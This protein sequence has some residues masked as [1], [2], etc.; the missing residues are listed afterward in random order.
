M[1]GNIINQTWTPAGSPYIVKGDITVPSGSFLNIQAG[2]EVQIANTDLQGAG[3]D[4]S[5]VEVTIKGSLDIAGT[6]MSPV[7][8]KAQLGSSKGIWYGIVADPAATLV[9][10]TNTTV[11]HAVSAIE[12]SAPGNVLQV[13]GSTFSVSSTGIHL[14]EGSPTLSNITLDQNSYG[15][16]AGNGSS[17]TL[18]G[19]SIQNSSSAGLA[20][21]PA[22]GNVSASITNCVIRS[23]AGYG[24][25]I[26][27][28]GGATVN[29]T[30]TST[31][32]HQ[33]GSYGVYVSAGGGSSS[34]VNIKSSN[35]T[36]HSNTGVFRNANATTSV[37]ITHSNVYAA[38]GSSRPGSSNATTAT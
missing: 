27:P 21:E 16:Y 38:T 8:F 9:K 13:S 25:Q 7:V 34:T 2:T 18:A 36:S 23:N 5:R 10:L 11:S 31:T 6:A 26:A 20:H 3:L 19:C 35:I 30:I 37:T 12:S 28:F 4:P 22:A 17:F 33:N 29:A 14:L 24:V 32:L 1:G 15:L